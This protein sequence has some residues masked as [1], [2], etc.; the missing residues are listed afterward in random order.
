MKKWKNTKKKR[1]TR[2]KT[3]Y[4]KVSIVAGYIKESVRKKNQKKNLKKVQKAQT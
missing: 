1:N 2:G 4:K 3:L